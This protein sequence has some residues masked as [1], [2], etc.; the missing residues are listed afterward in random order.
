MRRFHSSLE[1]AQ[2]GDKN[3]QQL[4]AF[5][6]GAGFAGVQ[7]SNYHLQK[8]DGTLMTVA[9]VQSHF[10]TKLR[11]DGI[12]AHCIFWVHTT[13]W[14]GSKTI[15]PFIPPEIA[16]KSPGKIE[17]WAEGYIFQL[18]ELAHG[19]KIKVI[20]MFW[21]VAFGWELATGYP[22]GFFSGGDYDLVMEGQERFVEKTEEIRT[23]AHSLGISLAHEIHPGTA[24]SCADDF[25]MLRKICNS[26]PTLGVNADPSHCWEGE[27]WEDRF[28]KVG[29]YITG[30]HVKDH[31]VRPGLPLRSMQSNWKERA[32]QFCRLGDGRIDLVRYS[33]LMDDVGYTKRYRDAHGTETAPLVG[34]AESPYYVLDEVS[35]AA[36]DFI[37]NRL[38]GDFTKSSFEDGMGAK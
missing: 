17:E 35:T 2:H 12:S 20:P 5:A 34:E 16:K 33:Q 7:P 30:C 11:L 18:L 4:V 10:D 28:T 32:M 24:A 14:T 27:G 22:W 3:L 8:P 1:A 23:R 38:C 31:I 25:L 13:A 36:S 29:P 19:L 9:E 21:G 26:D 15:R 6:S 37:R